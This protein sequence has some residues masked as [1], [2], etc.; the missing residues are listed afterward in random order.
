MGCSAS[1][2]PLL[3]LAAACSEWDQLLVQRQA[4]VVERVPEALA[5]VPQ[6]V[7]DVGI[8]DR[9]ESGSDR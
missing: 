4:L 6:V 3:G 8:W 1:P 7:L 5:L 2:S 9:L